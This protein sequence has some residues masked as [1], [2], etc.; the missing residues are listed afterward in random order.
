MS[1]LGLAHDQRGVQP[2]GL[3]RRSADQPHTNVDRGGGAAHY[4]VGV[5]DP[6]GFLL[7]TG[8]VVVLE[9]GDLAHSVATIGHRARLV[10]NRLDGVLRGGRE[11]CA[12]QC[13]VALVQ[14]TG[15]KEGAICQHIQ[16]IRDHI[17]ARVG[18]SIKAKVADDPHALADQGALARLE[19]AVAV[20]VDEERPFGL[21]R[22]SNGGR[23]GQDDEGGQDSG[24]D[25]LD[26][27]HGQVLL[28]GLVAGWVGQ[29][30]KECSVI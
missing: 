20:A 18:Q 16:V 9:S 10:P 12:W 27:V 22:L 3:R 23:G 7:P 14:A 17:I 28:C 29:V 13:D 30:E 2:V 21:H 1:Q 8:D 25:S 15:G 5:R 11:D 26:L 4:R 24:N 19:Q 6:R